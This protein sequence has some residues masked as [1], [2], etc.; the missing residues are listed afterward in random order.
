MRKSQLPYLVS[1]GLL[2]VA[3]AT[4]ADDLR[5]GIERQAA[6]IS[7]CSRSEPCLIEISERDQGY[8]VG[9]LKIVAIDEGGI[10]RA[11]PSKTYIMFDSK[12]RFVK[13]VGTP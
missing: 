10:A 5:K 6:E 7:G 12:G 13:K 3:G 2:L 1:A 4:A 8:S 11:L 9:V